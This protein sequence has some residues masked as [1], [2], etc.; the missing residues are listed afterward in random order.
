MGKALYIRIVIWI[1]CIFLFSLEAKGQIASFSFTGATGDENTFS[2][3]AQP[4]NGTI[5]DM[6][7]GAGI[8]VATLA[9]GFNSTNWSTTA[10]VATDD[11]YEF[12][13]T[14]DADYSI[15]LTSIQLDERYADLSADHTYNWVVRSSLDGF[16]ADL[17]TPFAVNATTAAAPATSTANVI[18]L[19]GGAFDDLTE[20]VTFRLYAYNT[21]QASQEW[22]I[23]NVTISGSITDIPPT[24]SA[25]T[26]DA[27][28]LFPTETSSSTV[29]SSQLSDIYLVLNG[30]PATTL[31]EITTAVAANNAFLGVDDA[32][33]DTPYTV[34][35]PSPL[36]DGTYDIVAVDPG[37]N[38][39]SILAGWLTVQ[40][41]PDPLLNSD[42]TLGTPTTSSVQISWPNAD[43][44]NI[45]VTVTPQSGTAGA[46]TNGTDYSGN[47]DTNYLV[48]GVVSDDSRVIYDGSG[49]S[50]TV[51]NLS[52]GTTYDVRVY[53]Y[54][55]AGFFYSTE[56][57]AS[58]TTDC[59]APAALANGDV[60]LSN[61]GTSS[62]DVSWPSS[63][64]VLVTVT[65]LS[66]TAANPTKGDDYSGGANADYSSAS[67][68][69]TSDSYV[70]YDGTGTS[71]SVTGLSVFTDYDVR[72][73]TYTPSGFCYAS[74]GIQSA[75]TNCV[76]PTGQAIFNASPPVTASSVDLSWA[77]VGDADSYVVFGTQG[78][79]ISFVPVDGTDYATGASSDFLTANDISG[80]KVLFSGAGTS[81]TV[82]NLAINQDFTFIIYAFN[83]ANN[84]YNTTGATSTSITTLTS[85][86]NNTVTFDNAAAT[87]NSVSNSASG[88]F[89]S[90]M[91]F[92][93]SDGGVD[94]LA[95]KLTQFVIRKGTNDSFADWTDV[96]GEARLV[97]TTTGNISVTASAINADNIVFPIANNNNN[98]NSDF[99]FV[100][101]AGTESYSLQIKILDNPAASIDNTNLVFNLS[102]VDISVEANSSGFVTPGTIIASGD[103]NNE[104]IVNASK[105]T[106]TTQPTSP[107]FAGVVTQPVIEARD[108]NDNID[109]DYANDITVSSAA[110]LSNTLGAGTGANFSSGVFTFPS[111]FSYQSSGNGT[112]TVSEVATPSIQGVSNAVTVNPSLNFTA[113]TNGLDADGDLESGTNGQNVAV[114]GFSIESLG[115]ANFQGLDITLST[116]P[117]N[118]VEN[119][120]IVSSANTTYEGIAT[121]PALGATVNIAGSIVS[122]SGLSEA[123]SNEVKHY[124]I[125]VD[126]ADEVQASTSNLSFTL[127]DEDFSFSGSAQLE[128]ISF[129]ED[130]SFSD[131]LA[132]VVTDLTVSQTLLSDDHVGAGGFTIAVTYNEPLD[133]SEAPVISFPNE[134]P[135]AS[136]TFANGVWSAGNTVYTATYDVVDNN[137]N[138][139]AIDIRVT[140]GRDLETPANVQA[141][142]NQAD[143][144]SIDT[145]NPTPVLSTLSPAVINVTNNTLT[146]AI[147][148]GEEMKSANTF[149]PVVTLS[150]QTNFTGPAEVSTGWSSG[151]TIYT[152][153]FTHNL[154]AEELSGAT[155]S[156]SGGEDVAGN[157]GISQTFVTPTFDI[158][159][160]EPT[161]QSII[162]TTTGDDR[163][164]VGE[165]IAIQLQFSESVSVVGNPQLNLNSGGIATFASVSGTNVNFTYT[166]GIGENTA[167]LDVTN[168]ALSGA[169]IQDAANNN[170]DL[171][172]PS[173]NSLADNEDIIIDTEAA[174]IVN[175]TATNANGFYA[176]GSIIEIEVEF[177]E[178]VLVTGTPVLALNTAGQASY[179]GG[180]NSNTLTFEYT[181][182]AGD[183]VSDLNYSNTGSL[184]LAGGTIR[185]LVNINA[186]LILPNTGAA[187][188]LGGNKNIV[189]DTKAPLLNTPSP[190]N[191]VDSALNVSLF[192]NFSIA[193]DEPV[194]GN[195][196]AN[197]RIIE[198]TS[199]STI[200]TLDGATAFTNDASAQSTKA[201]DLFTLQDT[202]EYYFEFDAGALL[203]RAG[204]PYAGFVGND[205]WFFTTFGPAR[206]ENFSTGACVGESFVVTGKYFTGVSKIISEDG[207]VEISSGDFITHTDEEI[208]FIVPNQMPEGKLQLE[209]VDP[210]NAGI[211]KTVVSDA[212]IKV[213][214]SSASFNIISLGSNNVC[215]DAAGG[216]PVA[217][218]VEVQIIGGVGPFFLRYTDGTTIY[219][220]Q[221]YVKGQTIFLNPSSVGDN[222]F[223]ILELTDEDPDLSACSAPNLGSGVVITEYARSV[224]EA[225][226][227]AGIVE[228]CLAETSE[229]DLSDPAI[230][231]LPSITGDVTSGVWTIEQGPTSGGGGFGAGSNPPKTTTA[232]RPTYYPSLS[233]AAAGEIVL[234]LTS[235]DPSAPN[236][237]NPAEDLL[238][239]RFTTSDVANEGPDQNICYGELASLQGSS[240]TGQLE[241]SRDDQFVEAGAHDGSWGFAD[242]ENATVFTLTTT[243]E[244]PFYKPSPQELANGNAVLNLVPVVSGGGCGGTPETKELI[245][246]I[247]SLPITEKSASPGIVCSGQ[248]R[249]LFSM[250]PS[251]ANSSFQW[252]VQNSGVGSDKNEIN[253]SSTNNELFVSFREVNAIAYDTIFVREINTATGCISE[254]DT[255]AIEIKPL[256]E[257]NITYT[258][259]TLLSNTGTPI[260]LTG[261]GGQPGNIQSGG[262]FAQTKGI[263]LREDG[264]YYFDPTAVSVTD[265]DNPADNIE[266]TFYYTD[267]FGCTNTDVIEFD[268]FDAESIFEGLSSEYCESDPETV[269]EVN[270]AVLGSEF[271]VV[272]IYGPGVT[273][274]TAD[275]TATFS[276]SQALIDLPGSGQKEIHYEIKNKSDLGAPAQEGG[277]QITT[278]YALPDLSPERSIETADGDPV[279]T[280]SGAILLEKNA[281]ENPGNNY[282]FYLEGSNAGIITGN[283]GS[284]FLLNPSVLYD[285]MVQESLEKIDLNIVYEYA[286]ENSSATTC[287]DTTYVPVTIFRRPDVPTLSENRLCIVNGEIPTAEITNEVEVEGMDIN[288]EWYN[289][290][291]L[292]GEA[293]PLATTQLFTP[294]VDDLS[295]D[296]ETNFY[297]FRVA[298]G[299]RS[300]VAVVVYEVIEPADFSWDKSTFGDGAVNFQ[301]TPPAGVN[302]DS[303]SWTLSK[304]EGQSSNIVHTVTSANE[305]FSYDFAQ[306]GEGAY[307]VELAVN[308]VAGCAAIHAD[309]VLIL[310]KLASL[311]AGGFSFDSGSQGWISTSEASLNSWEVAQPTVQEGFPIEHENNVWITNADGSY[312]S[313]E[314][315]YVYSP[316]MDISTIERPFVSFD[317]WIDLIE[318]SDGMVLQYSYD[319]EVIG[320]PDKEWILI[321]DFQNGISSGPNWYNAL[322]IRSRP[323]DQDNF[324]YGWSLGTD[325]W[326]EAKHV[327]DGIPLTQR[328]NLVFRFAF[329]AIATPGDLPDGVAFDNFQILSRNRKVLIEYFGD[330]ASSDQSEM[331]TIQSL[332]DANPDE[333]VWINYRINTDDSLYNTSESGITARSFFYD[334]NEGVSRAAIDGNYLGDA[335]FSQD[336]LN[337]YSTRSLESSPVEI[338][339]SSTSI[340]DRT[341]GIDV[342]LDKLVELPETAVLQVALVKD[343]IDRDGTR[344]YQVLRRFLPDSYG[345][346]IGETTDFSFEWIPN[347]VSDNEGIGAIAF[348][349]DMADK[350]VL[351]TASLSSLASVNPVTALSPSSQLGV[352]GVYPNPAN[353]H[354]TIAFE[355]AVKNTYELSVID[356]TGKALH[357]QSVV[358]GTRE[359]RLDTKMLKSGL[360]M[361]QLSGNNGDGMLLKLVVKH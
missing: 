83:N 209:K 293:Q 92:T 95:T 202:T 276:P 344:Y 346:Q 74:P 141:A 226:G 166:V 160:Q 10:T 30:E 5:S 133:I 185:D 56:A 347:T 269:I 257:A 353:T 189:I 105:F 148:Y 104:I 224:V 340:D 279:N 179:T 26:S 270:E 289:N 100:T 59:T 90:A 307:S 155:V 48:A 82:T 348:V 252:T 243:T 299:V 162:S 150:A 125:I 199:G 222:T 313:G 267:P 259:S 131:R 286:Q 354:V 116:L 108:A 360:Y 351:Q 175:V 51:T 284:G 72:V 113:L 14:P 261:E 338:E 120:R 109:L 275:S 161:L 253:G 248:E 137:T 218:E 232:L 164:T 328:S 260:R 361:V 290:L 49:T 81:L 256:P 323:G 303:Y 272:N 302:V 87:V 341:I 173:G 70:V 190:F 314:V 219:E 99:G 53:V 282:S 207:T 204:N 309:T 7:R 322:N 110:N 13:V 339:L 305:A 127:T 65:E 1:F 93:I 223:E 213:G 60:S 78:N 315:S 89:V 73:Y 278:V 80:T 17:V 281:Q 235:N 86:N 21:S 214:P 321:G 68:I 297:A 41:T 203:D 96:I 31:A 333:V 168:V 11:Y 23:D 349:Q 212:S 37:G 151:N 220:V 142:Y 27:E 334:I 335:L 300:E 319:N 171:S 43:S 124:F 158:D 25:P 198:Q 101:D 29:Q 170:A 54:S 355:T 52:S 66:G 317:L 249:V 79:S 327:L 112:L 330:L 188:S 182:Q 28:T 187:N 225:G 318:E 34:T 287:S 130:Y 197:I 135:T 55:P 329:S 44:D 250:N 357:H 266:V 146:V 157:T 221:N 237:C 227:T 200:L 42:I 230:G 312:N 217:T 208:E 156:V 128:D 136:I 242:S 140:N 304:I 50:V 311:P 295:S 91:D 163:Y 283:S 129:S 331:N 359:I 167:D 255:F 174:Q 69:N 64:N 246:T 103:S 6:S 15:T 215:N 22:G 115:S 62:L 107:I 245:L 239:I 47:E 211:I 337:E 18:D 244:D 40:N 280:G 229:I 310:P 195:G 356:K 196:T 16:T 277:F 262:V 201:L 121:D 3:D 46:P 35:L 84:C 33:A 343:T 258:G 138:V 61:I 85:S 102:P 169:T 177:N 263:I 358:P 234:K 9:D 298:N 265:I 238:I 332:F 152:V 98:N 147:D 67:A 292:V 301:I 119:I 184:T 306:D 296:N 36:N 114:L 336:G 63:G 326:V 8:S 274:N 123:L 4:A 316:Y 153:T 45:L 24:V 352:T 58:T 206:I 57:I 145:E 191:P 194:I 308:S 273:F 180:S 320:S 154:T 241:W 2:V 139:S 342:T 236:P 132:P 122:I 97:N 172:I 285:S 106:F 350:S 76:E 71:V 75:Q 271:V 294:D 183:N 291:S 20:A 77:A 193:F 324:S 210:G 264:F 32:T 126:V 240:S 228:V 111:D 12:T 216:A 143:Q 165:V 19:T 117:A 233:D 251:T 288:Y 345:T 118:K 181:V 149:N 268:I 325:G 247:N 231:T 186:D 254:Q 176:A 39:S 178:V 192:N 144:F 88:S 94:N 159:T 205:E 134:D 38:V